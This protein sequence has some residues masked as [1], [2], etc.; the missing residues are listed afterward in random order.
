VLVAGLVLT[1]SG[2]LVGERLLGLLG[3]ASGALIVLVGVGLLVTAV[4]SLRGDGAGRGWLRGHG[5]THEHG[6]GHGHE[7]AQGQGHEHGHG[8]AHGHGLGHAHQH[9]HGPEHRRE[10]RTSFG[11]PSLL[12]VGLAGG[13]VPSPSALVVLLGAVSLSRTAF[14]VLLVVAYGLGMALTLTSAGLLLSGTGRLAA[15]CARRLPGR[16]LARAGRYAALLT[17]LTVLAVG[18]ALTV[19]GVTPR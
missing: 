2:G 6:Q 12:G 8:R 10:K 16:Q 4:R 5:H 15:L 7:P 17:A 1:A 14:G 13:L 3:T 19:R 18:L 9:G 11:L